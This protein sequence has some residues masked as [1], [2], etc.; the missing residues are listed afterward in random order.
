MYNNP[1]TAAM[2]RSVSRLRQTGPDLPGL[3]SS[4]GAETSVLPPYHAKKMEV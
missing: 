3:L 4:I 2:R 1:Y